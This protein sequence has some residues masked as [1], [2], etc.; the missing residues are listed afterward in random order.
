[1]ID[2]SL[3]ALSAL[4]SR[5]V[6]FLT[7]APSRALIPWSSV[8]LFP[9]WHTIFALSLNPAI[10]ISTFHSSLLVSVS[11]CLFLGSVAVFLLLFI[12]PVPSFLPSFLWFMPT[13]LHIAA[14]NGKLLNLQLLLTARAAS[15]SQCD[16]QLAA[17][18]GRSQWT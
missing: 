3:S 15:N 6:F 1:M 10:S 7:I 17:P 4:S 12:L 14:A 16:E 8:F 9:R 18:L 13:A 5:F 11:D 2:V